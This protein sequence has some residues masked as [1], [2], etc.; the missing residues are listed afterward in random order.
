MTHRVAK[1]RRACNRR[2]SRLSRREEPKKVACKPCSKKRLGPRN[3]S[4]P[5]ECGD[6]QWT[7]IDAPPPAR[8]SS[9]EFFCFENCS[10]GAEPPFDGTTIGETVITGCEPDEPGDPPP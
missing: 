7:W 8:W 3:V 1:S 6:C 10:C 2:S 4:D 5:S 9:T